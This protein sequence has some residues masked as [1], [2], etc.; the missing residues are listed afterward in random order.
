M[1]NQNRPNGE[2]EKG[3]QLAQFGWSSG[4]VLHSRCQL[5]SWA[6]VAVLI[7]VLP[8]VGGENSP[9]GTVSSGTFHQEANN[10]LPAQLGGIPP[11]RGG[12]GCGRVPRGSAHASCGAESTC[13]RPAAHFGPAPKALGCRE[14]EEVQSSLGFPDSRGSGRGARERALFFPPLFSLFFSLWS[15]WGVLVLF[16]LHVGGMRMGTGGSEGIGDER[17][18]ARQDGKDKR[19]SRYK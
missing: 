2:A 9:R 16:Y 10:C 13:E 17:E 6:F 7:T 1:R 5:A 11:R 3:K 8:G 15:S 12:R 19:P 18:I 14:A 4:L